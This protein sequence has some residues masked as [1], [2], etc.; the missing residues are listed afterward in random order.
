MGQLCFPMPAS[1]TEERVCDDVPARGLRLHGYA[2]ANLPAAEPGP[3][4]SATFASASKLSTRPCNPRMSRDG[5]RYPASRARSARHKDNLRISVGWNCSCSS[6][7]PSQG[8]L[9]PSRHH[10]LSAR[11]RIRKNGPQKRS[12]A[13]ESR[14]HGTEIH[15]LNLSH[16]LVD[17]AL[18]VPEDKRSTKRLRNLVQSCFHNGPVFRMH[19]HLKG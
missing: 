3:A 12:P 5:R 14:F 8:D 17:K 1:R 2:A 6:R 13:N 7:L 18:N 16:F 9:N 10:F 15:I 11:L 4:P 19:R